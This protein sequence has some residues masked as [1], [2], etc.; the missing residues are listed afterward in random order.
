MRSPDAG[1]L[2]LTFLPAMT[3][4]MVFASFANSPSGG[5]VETVF[6]P[7]TQCFFFACFP[8][9]VLSPV[10]QPPSTACEQGCTPSAKGD[11][12]GSRSTTLTLSFAG[13]SRIRPRRAYPAAISGGLAVAAHRAVQP[14]HRDGVEVRRVGLEGRRDPL[15]A[16]VALDRGEQPAGPVGSVPKG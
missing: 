16:R 2:G 4:A 14:F 12:P 8:A 6:T 11:P 1:P 15:A 10:R 7:L 5:K 3:R 13:A 9:I